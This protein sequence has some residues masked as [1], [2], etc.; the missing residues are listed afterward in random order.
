MLSATIVLV[1]TERDRTASRQVAGEIGD[2]VVDLTGR[3][4]LGATLGLAHGCTLFVGND[5]GPRHL[6]AATGTPTVGIFW[7]GNAITF[8]PLVGAANRASISFTVN[9]PVCGVEQSRSRCEHD[10]SLVDSV[11]PDAVLRECLEAV[12]HDERPGVETAAGLG[13]RL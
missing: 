1:G 9:C 10:A 2:G 5:S 6:A 13:R 4:S 11:A 3:L 8:G 7:V 12:R